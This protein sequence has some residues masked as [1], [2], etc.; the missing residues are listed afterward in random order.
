[1]EKNVNKR[2]TLL[3]IPFLL[4]N[5]LPYIIRTIA[6]C[7]TGEPLSGFMCTCS[8]LI[9]VVLAILLGYFA[10][11]EFG[12]KSFSDYCSLAV[13][14]AFAIAFYKLFT[15][16][17]TAYP[18]KLIVKAPAVYWIVFVLVGFM[19]PS[20]MLAFALLRGFVNAKIFFIMSGVS[21]AYI[22][23]YELYTWAVSALLSFAS[24]SFGTI[25]CIYIMFAALETITL[26]PVIT[27]AT[28]FSEPMEQPGKS[29]KSL[30]L[31]G[32]IGLVVSLGAGIYLENSV[33]P[34]KAIAID[35]DE[36]VANGSIALL[37]GDIELAHSSYEQ[38]YNKYLGWEGALEDK[39]NGLSGNED[40][41]NV[42]VL[43]W[44]KYKY[45]NKYEDYLLYEDFE[46]EVAKQY[47]EICQQNEN[48]YSK[49]S[50]A[51]KADIKKYLIGTD[52]F[53]RESVMIKDFEDSKDKAL[54]KLS[55][56]R[57]LE[58]YVKA[59]EILSKVGQEGEITG[60]TIKKML[61]IASN[62]RNE[63][64]IQYLTF[65]ISCSQR[66]EGSS[67]YKE[68][69]DVGERLLELYVEQYGNDNGAQK[70]RKI[71]ASYCMDVHLYD[72][73]LELFKEHNAKDPS[74]DNLLMIAGCHIGNSDYEN[75]IKTSTE[76]LSKEPNN[77]TARYLLAMSY[78]KTGEKEASLEEGKKLMNALTDSNVDDKEYYN[79][80][81]YSL[82]GYYVLDETSFKFSVEY[83]NSNNEDILA[84]VS[85][86]E[87]LLN[88]MDAMHYCFRS[89]DLP[90]ALEAAEKVEA[91]IGKNSCI[92][93]LKGCILFAQKEY[94]SAVECF[95]ISV[96]KDPESYTSW[97]A[98]A[99]A[100]DGMEMYEEAL[101][102][103]QTAKK[104]N[105]DTD[106]DFDWYGVGI[107][108]NNFISSMER[109]LGK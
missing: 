102:A 5:L 61:D 41:I 86:C 27:M 50:E 90:R 47:L 17:I 15:N 38:A 36:S 65:A 108:V 59:T 62:N 48:Y 32:V 55:I 19:I 97:Y 89:K 91:A 29:A 84:K 56:Y 35:I 94:A 37:N 33:A 93:Y 73:A 104:I 43:F 99:N 4:L 11:K 95:K 51:I 54:E 14:G 16:Y 71:V 52:N 26:V 7:V 96:E 72:I 64:G 23:L 100:Y 106:H 13:M 77:Y 2:I 68:V 58:Y 83:R 3:F 109:K 76:V 103:A 85:E 49:H 98:L 78:L 6:F 18:G 40:D 66:K 8:D 107:H 42:K 44:Q 10:A 45:I 53:R 30:A 74:T 69:A 46:P 70:I 63:I 21:L 28:T 34:W 92:E 9:G 39:F 80:M 67:Y 75:V 57:N 105:P 88:Y 31:A 82:I 1:M 87:L 79:K 20:C 24:A 22:V 101:F 12:F 25:S 60:N 81:V